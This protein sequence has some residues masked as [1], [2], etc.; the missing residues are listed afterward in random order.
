[1]TG[2]WVYLHGEV[3]V[4]TVRRPDDVRL[5]VVDAGGAA[6]FCLM[7]TVN[8]DHQQTGR[9]AGDADVFLELLG[10]PEDLPPW[11]T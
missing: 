8:V 11:V 6:K 2:P 10:P 1:L 9:P 5:E 3:D 4:P 7:W